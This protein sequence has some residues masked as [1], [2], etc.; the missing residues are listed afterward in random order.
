MLYQSQRVGMCSRVPDLLISTSH[1][2][3]SLTWGQLLLAFAGSFTNFAE[4]AQAVRLYGWSEDTAN[5][6]CTWTGI[7]CGDDTFA[8]SLRNYGLNG[9]LV[10]MQ[11][12]CSPCCVCRRDCWALC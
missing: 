8:I 6:P 11:G 9:A 7:S 10:A 4:T 3:G 2:G 1:A 12:C 5:E